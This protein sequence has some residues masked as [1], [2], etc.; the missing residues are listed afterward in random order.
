MINGLSDVWWNKYKKI[1]ASHKNNWANHNKNLACHKKNWSKKLKHYFG[2][3]SL[4]ENIN[5]FF[6]QTVFAHAQNLSF[7]D[8]LR[9]NRNHSVTLWLINLS[10]KICQSSNGIQTYWSNTRSRWAT[11]QVHKPPTTWDMYC[12]I[13]FDCIC[14]TYFKKKIKDVRKCPNQTECAL[15]GITIVL[16]DLF[17][18][19]LRD[20]PRKM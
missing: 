13:V 16:N 1:R 6:L 19:P 8:A 18:L 12:S 7:S 11:W 9:I 20:F 4:R 3:R 14:R 5:V 10:N 15:R 2:R 17:C